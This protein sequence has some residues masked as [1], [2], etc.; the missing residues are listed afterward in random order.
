MSLNPP[1]PDR[2]ETD[3]NRF[4]TVAFYAAL[5]RA[6]VAMCGVVVGLFLIEVINHADGDRLNNYGGI[7]PHHLD[8]LDG[9]VFAPFLHA[10]FAH[11]YANAVPLLLTGTFALAI[12]LR[13]FL[14][15]TALIAVVSGL[16]VWFVASPK[17]IV[18]GASG[19]ILGYIGFLLVRG[20]VE[21]SWWGIAVGVLIGL[22]YGTQI[23][24]EV[25]PGNEQVSWQA[26]LFGLVGGLLAAIVFRRRPRLRPQI[27]EPL[28]NPTLDLPTLD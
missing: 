20:I 18:V 10:S 5:G 2:D 1:V 15:V 6:F 22:L 8:G 7:R 26:H 3:P 19:V 28:T 17:Y 13:R 21:R 12:G 11:F 16:G 4:G 9:V 14:G 23:F 25:T 27:P 24:G